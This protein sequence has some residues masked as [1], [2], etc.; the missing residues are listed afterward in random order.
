MRISCSII[1]SG[2]LFQGVRFV[3]I[4]HPLRMFQPV[5]QRTTHRFLMAGQIMTPSG[6]WIQKLIRENVMDVGGA[7]VAG[8]VHFL[9]FYPGGYPLF[10]LS[11]EFCRD[12]RC[13]PAHQKMQI[14]QSLKGGGSCCQ[15]IPLRHRIMKT[16]GT[17]SLTHA[18][19][20]E[21]I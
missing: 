19:E 10:P 1:I 4:L 11:P 21:L 20:L 2:L 13:Y 17:S 7:S 3:R 14:P 16:P 5:I 6:G 18:R 9:E 15:M 12:G 8:E